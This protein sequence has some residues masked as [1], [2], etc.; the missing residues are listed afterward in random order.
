[1]FDE[2]TSPGLDLDG[3]MVSVNLRQ[4]SD[5]AKPILMACVSTWLRGSGAAATGAA[6]SWSRRR[7]GTC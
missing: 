1:M 4:V 6:G 5:A 2:K 7:P 3:P